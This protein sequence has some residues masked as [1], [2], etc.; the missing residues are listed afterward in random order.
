MTTGELGPEVQKRRNVLNRA[1]DAFWNN[2]AILIAVAAFL[3]SVTGLSVKL[4]GND[5][6]TFQIVLVPGLLCFAATS[7]VVTAY[8][9]GPLA[10]ASA[11]VGGLTLLRGLLGATSITCFYLAI[12]LLPLQD[13][14]TLFFCSPVL[15]ALLE[16]A[17]TGESHGWAG[18]AATTCTVCGVV[19]VS[20]PECLFRRGGHSM[21]DRGSSAAGVILATTAAAA[22]AA[23]FVVVRLLKRSQ[24][25]VVLTW[26]YHGVVVT[27]AA[28]PLALGYPAPAVAPSA[29]S[30]CLLGAVGATQF[31]GQLL[32]N[33]G[34]Q[35]ESATRGSAINVLQVLFSFLWDLAI[36]GD[37]PGL[38]SATGSGL[39]AAGVLFVA[40]TPVHQ[41][42]APAAAEE[43][44]QGHRHGHGHGHGQH[45]VRGRLHG[46]ADVEAE[47]APL[48]GAGAAAVLASRRGGGG[49]GGGGLGLIEEDVGAVEVGRGGGGVRGA[50]AAPGLV[51]L[52]VEE[53]G[54]SR[55]ALSS[56]GSGESTPGLSVGG[57]SRDRGRGG[58]GA[59]EGDWQ[60]QQPLLVRVVGRLSMDTAT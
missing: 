4:I 37:K 59:E 32:L 33:R 53:G 7:A 44:V 18:A 2:G 43:A 27:V 24:N 48:L 19:L 26:W 57:P 51:H 29:R 45:R 21:E 40:L 60:L 47:A 42:L 35:L 6:P 25:T 34:F 55:E 9:P 5:L 10:S 52:H 1:F 36:L 13:A 23:A 22:N 54:G 46:E 58:S 39:V 31:A 8:R 12:E 20:Q 14:V 16:L 15:A 50:L 17:V 30:G 41:H 11:Y 38:V 28:V 56:S 49:G 3:F